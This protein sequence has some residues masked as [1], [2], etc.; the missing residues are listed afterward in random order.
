MYF[1][2]SHYLI[3]ISLPRS[4]VLSNHCRVQNKQPTDSDAQ[5]R[6]GG[7]F[8][9]RGCPGDFPWEFSEGVKYRGE[10]SK[11]GL[12]GGDLSTWHVRERTVLIAMQD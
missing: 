3:V 9:E 2:S 4:H 5:L 1:H 6:S 8:C 11:E 10:M 7:E 12:S